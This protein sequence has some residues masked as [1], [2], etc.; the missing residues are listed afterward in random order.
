MQKL[1]LA[2]N[3]SE[4]Q[5]YYVKKHELNLNSHEIDEMDRV[6]FMVTLLANIII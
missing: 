5:I 1:N 2:L 3:I 6:I 4:I